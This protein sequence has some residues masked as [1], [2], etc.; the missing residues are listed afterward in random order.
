MLKHIGKGDMVITLDVTG[1]Q[2]DTFELA[3]QLQHWREAARDV[4]LLI[5]GPDGLGREC[6]ERANQHWSL[7][8]LTL[9]HPLVRI[10]LAEQLYRALTIC[11][12]HPYHRSG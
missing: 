3:Q 12:G 11:Q 2:W 4:C 6:L 10:L 9:P 8:K 1:K 5:G 7:S